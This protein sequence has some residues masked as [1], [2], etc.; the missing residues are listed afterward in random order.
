M[1]RKAIALVLAGALLTACSSVENPVTGK[2]ERTVMSE[3]DEADAGSEQHRQVLADYGEAKD[4]RLQAYVN[5]V[6]QK[7]A[8]NSQRPE[9]RWR[10]TVLDSARSMPLRCR[11]AMSM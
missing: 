5:D 7:L 10:F 1:S 6:G 8:R 4:A 2:T 3:Q 9:L 11:A